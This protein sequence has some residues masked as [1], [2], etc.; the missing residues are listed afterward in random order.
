MKNVIKSFS[1]ILLLF[2]GNSSSMIQIV[3]LKN[4]VVILYGG[5]KNNINLIV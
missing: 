3:D 2:I 4:R 1:F 5:Y